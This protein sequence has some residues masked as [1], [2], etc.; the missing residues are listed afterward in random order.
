MTAIVFTI[1]PVFAVALAGYIL[2]RS[3]LISAEGVKG[4]SNVTFY[5]FVPAL[6]FRAMRTVH[7]DEL[8]GRPLL[9]YFGGA[10]LIFAMVMAA[11]R[12]WLKRSARHA[13][14]TALAVTFSNTVLLGIPLIKLSY[15]DPGLVILLT[16]IS[17]HA[18]VL[19]STATLFL[20]F[21]GNPLDDNATRPGMGRIQLWEPLRNTFL[22]PVILP[23]LVGLLWGL[24]RLPVSD[25]IDAPLALLGT[26]AGPCSLVLLGASLA[27]YGIAEHWRPA[28]TLTVLKNLVFPLLIWA[29][30][31]YVLG[32]SGL[33]LAVVTVTAALP[34]G[35]N[36]FLFAQR[37]QVAQG[38]ITAAVAL[39]TAA[40]VIT[41]TAV[42]LLFG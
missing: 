20:E 8:D 36:V 31:A 41:L 15:G 12:R 10:L 42:M 22:S 14:V 38:E 40:S 11:S 17:L 9:A 1:L 18:L 5:L 33:A 26:A 19:Y 7:F 35:A 2:S 24:F 13:T 16:I 23:I 4:F 34:I 30:G 37:Y 25:S 32:L 21:G 27:H 3:G 29:I 28:A 6:L 39:S